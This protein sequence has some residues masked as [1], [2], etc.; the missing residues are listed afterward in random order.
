MTSSWK[1][2]LRISH[3]KCQDIPK[4]SYW[5][6]CAHQ[7]GILPFG[8]DAHFSFL[9][10]YTDSL[11][12]SS[13]TQLAINRITHVYYKHLLKLLSFNL[14]D[15]GFLIC[16]HLDKWRNSSRL[17]K[18]L[19]F[20]FYNVGFLIYSLKI[21]ALFRLEASFGIG[22]GNHLFG[23]QLKYNTHIYIVRSFISLLRCKSLLKERKR[24]D[25][26]SEWHFG[27]KHQCVVLMLKLINFIFWYLQISNPNPD[28][29]TMN[30]INMNLNLNLNLPYNN[31]CSSS[32]TG[33][34]Q[35]SIHKMPPRIIQFHTHPSEI[36][37]SSLIL[38]LPCTSPKPK[39][40][41]TPLPATG[42]C[43]GGAPANGCRRSGSPGN[44]IGF[45]WGHS[46]RRK[47]PPLRTTSRR[48]L[49]RAPTPTST[50]RTRR[51]R[52]PCLPPPLHVIFRL[53]PPPPQRQ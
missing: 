21:V 51:R 24:R 36:K 17:L 5:L 31:A 50:F 14:Y 30:M 46:L 7:F 45:G 4:F 25:L 42:G 2:M 38:E 13:Q 48:W 10:S 28:V 3:L 16:H 29:S 49:W 43:G 40:A 41:P 6:F 18:L 27:H 15:V 34:H 20:N 22:R 9:D 32:T 23:H 37:T 47:W 11:V 12:F 39:L 35:F 1:G 53:Q 52:C 44:P 26:V 33:L 19:S 8:P